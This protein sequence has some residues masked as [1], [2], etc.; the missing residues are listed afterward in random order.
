MYIHYL[1]KGQT[2]SLNLP[3]N[4]YGILHSHPEKHE[5]SQAYQSLMDNTHV[6]QRKASH[7]CELVYKMS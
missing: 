3:N 6:N 4:V 2:Y 5:E 1:N 7:I